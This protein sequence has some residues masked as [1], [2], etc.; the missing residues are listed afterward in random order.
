MDVLVGPAPGGAVLDPLFAWRRAVPRAIS[1][2]PA[3]RGRRISEAGIR[4]LRAPENRRFQS[5]VGGPADRCPRPGHRWRP[6]ADPQL[7][8]VNLLI[9]RRPIY[10]LS[11]ILD[12]L[13]FDL[14][15]AA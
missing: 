9:P 15:L 7:L 10:L 8:P 14:S 6:P 13:R 11:S 4:R 3:R 1:S 5:L 12:L 2:G